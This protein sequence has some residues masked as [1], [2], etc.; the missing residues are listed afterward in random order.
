MAVV[1]AALI[2]VATLVL[3]LFQV[4]AAGMAST[5]N[6]RSGAGR[7]LTIGLSAAAAVAA[8]HYI[9]LSW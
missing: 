6:A 3:A 8:S 5:G 2:V 1:L 9:G 7:T 4:L